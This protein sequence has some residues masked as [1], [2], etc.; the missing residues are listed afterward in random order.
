MVGGTQSIVIHPQ[1]FKDENNVSH[2][3]K[4]QNVSKFTNY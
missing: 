3:K 1:Q 4:P 2:F